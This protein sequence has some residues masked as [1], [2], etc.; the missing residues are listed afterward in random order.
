MSLAQP[1]QRY[2][3]Q[4]R[5]KREDPDF[6]PNS[7]QI[8]KYL[9]ETVYS[10]DI[11]VQEQKEQ[12]NEEKFTISQQLSGTC[13]GQAIK[14]FLKAPGLSTTLVLLNLLLSSDRLEI[15]L[16]SGFASTMSAKTPAT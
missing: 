8:A 2:R 14:T 9:Y 3:A 4:E 11:L 5:E 15:T 1:E 10:S 16:S 12:K 6:Q 7:E 13:S